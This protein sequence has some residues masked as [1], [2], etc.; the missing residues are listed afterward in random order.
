MVEIINKFYRFFTPCFLRNVVSI[1]RHRN[2]SSG[3]IRRKIIRYYSKFSENELTNEQSQV[4]KYLKRNP[5]NIFPYSF[6]KKYNQDKVEVY[7]D[8]KKCLQFVYL[9]GKRLYFK[10]GYSDSLLKSKFN[11]LCIEQDIESPHRYLSDY[12]FINNGDIVADIGAAEGNFALGL[13]EK[14]KKIYLFESDEGWIEALNATFEPWKAK[15]EIINKS[16][17]DKTDNENLQ[18]D[19]FF[20]NKELN[21]IK[22]DTEG[23]ELKVLNGSKVIISNQNNLK[24]AVCTYHKQ[25]D[26]LLFSEFLTNFGFYI[27]KPQGY[28]IYIHDNEYK[29]PYLKRGLIRASK[30]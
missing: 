28:M 8:K 25:N 30:M 14:A 7:F 10:R 2:E 13:V 19:S 26:E 20:K 24:I 3:I 1:Y 12:F 23:S 21:F 15:V 18:L 9:D 6:T 17:S 29:E 4:I 27:Y 5:L 16:V 11:N 22:I